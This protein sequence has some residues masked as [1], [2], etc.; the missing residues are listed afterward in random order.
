MPRLAISLFGPF[1]V[2]LDGTPVT[3]FKTNKV[4]AL[5]AY[6][7]V[8]ADRAHQRNHIQRS[9]RRRPLEAGRRRFY[10][11]WLKMDTPYFPGAR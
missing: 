6:L 8:E 1:H 2:T 10:L 9:Y 3:E 7:A 11:Q 5:L 4:Q